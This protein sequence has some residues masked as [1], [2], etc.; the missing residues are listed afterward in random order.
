MNCHIC[1]GNLDTVAQMANMRRVTSD[2]RAWPSGGAI[3]V[4]STCGAVQKVRDAA[5]HADCQRI[6]RSY[7]AYRQGQGA[8]QAVFVD[9]VGQR[10]SDL[11]ISRIDDVSPLASSGRL[12]DVGCGMGTLLSAFK[13]Q[14]P[15][16]HL[17][18]Q[19]LGDA[20]LQ[21]VEAIVGK[22]NFVSG[23]LDQVPG[24]FDLVTAIHV[25]EHVEHPAAFLQTLRERLTP[26]GRIFV[27]VPN[28]DAN[29]FDLLIVDHATHFS[30]T[31]LG[32]VI[33]AGGCARDVLTGDWVARELSALAKPG[34]GSAIE[35]ESPERSRALVRAHICWLDDLRGAAMDQARSGGLGIFGTSIAGTWLAS[36]LGNAVE[37]FVDE[38]TTRVGTNHMGRPILA[39]MDTAPSARVFMPMLPVAAK[40]VA[41]RLSGAPATFILPPDLPGSKM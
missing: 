25:L 6:Y 32:Q 21:S 38:D 4:C 28:V 39:P 16:W 23:D 9:G 7:I 2:C 20:H 18:G 24:A 22:G 35:V 17:V 15:D 30:A 12:L 11:L 33:N 40:S 29:P 10:R 5:W 19:D 8:E 41:A 31:I 26:S 37:F 27:Q 34:Q 36:E 1:D 13:R 14:R 3:A